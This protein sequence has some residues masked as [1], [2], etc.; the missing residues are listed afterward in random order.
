MENNRLSEGIIDE[1]VTLT[2]KEFCEICSVKEEYII[3]MVH[4][5]VLEPVGK[6]ISHWQFT[7][8]Q[9]QRF[10]KAQRLQ[11]DL[12]LNMEGVALSLE[13]L[14]QL[15][16]LRKKINSLERQLKLFSKP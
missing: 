2:F 3:E 14:D 7:L 8:F 10:K 16:S 4:L 1:T 12:E 9:L 5:G 11:A 15:T 13:L 6:H